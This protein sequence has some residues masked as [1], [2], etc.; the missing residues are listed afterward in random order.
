MTLRI[1]AVITLMSV[2]FCCKNSS[3]RIFL[4]VYFLGKKCRS[5]KKCKR[6]ACPGNQECSRDDDC[7]ARHTAEEQA[8]NTDGWVV[9]CAAGVPGAS[10]LPEVQSLKRKAWWVA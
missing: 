5:C 7:S 4:P 10:G 6:W 1:T 2:C 9:F 8:H 3:I